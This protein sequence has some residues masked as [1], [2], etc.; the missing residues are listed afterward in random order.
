MRLFW[1]MHAILWDFWMAQVTLFSYANYR[2][3]SCWRFRVIMRKFRVISRIFFSLFSTKMT[4]IGFRTF[5][6][7]QTQYTC[8]RQFNMCSIF[9]TSDDFIVK[10]FKKSFKPVILLKKIQQLYNQHILTLR[11]P[12]NANQFKISSTWS[13]LGIF[14]YS[15]VR[16]C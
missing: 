13:H 9:R 12:K 15:G 8:V 7:H 6:L 4:S 5:S 1:N 11:I 3:K 2:N 10:Y 16:K 14:M